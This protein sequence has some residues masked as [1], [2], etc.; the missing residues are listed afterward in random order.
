[1]KKKPDKNTKPEKIKAS[2][3]AN[4]KKNK[5]T[6]NTV[7]TDSSVTNSEDQNDNYPR[8]IQGLFE[9]LGIE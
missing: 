9:R 1:M 4:S 2:K 8:D 3:M 5:I 7:N 6:I